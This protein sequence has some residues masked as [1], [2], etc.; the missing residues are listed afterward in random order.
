MDSFKRRWPGVYAV[1]L[2]VNNPKGQSV[3]G[4]R[5]PDGGKTWNKNI[6]VYSSPSGT[7]CECCRPSVEVTGNNVYVMFRNFLNGNRDFYL[8]ESSD[9]GKTFGQAQK[10]GSGSWKLDGCPMDGGGIA[11]NKNKTPE[12]V[13][14]R[15][16]KFIQSSPASLNK[17]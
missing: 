6:I 16:E 4:A 15:Q 10:L 14:R 5:S 13:W 3:Y 17:K 8:T 9:N 11:I 7:V 1:W 2:G 12:T